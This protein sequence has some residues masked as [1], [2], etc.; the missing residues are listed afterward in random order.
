[1]E[2]KAEGTATPSLVTNCVTSLDESQDREH[3][4]TVIKDVAGNFFVGESVVLLHRV[5]VLRFFRQSY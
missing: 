3:Q 4:L 2:S 1:M 5:L